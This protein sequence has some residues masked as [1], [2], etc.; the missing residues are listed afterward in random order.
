MYK[1]TLTD[2][3]IR[4][5]DGSIIP[6][7]ALN[8]DYKT[9]LIWAAQGNTAAAADVS[10]SVATVSALQGMLAIGQNPALAAAY[11]SWANDPGRTFAQRAFID[12]AQTWRRDDL[13]LAAAATAFG[14]SGEQV[15]GL[16][17]LA[18]TL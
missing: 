18:A 6:A 13:T 11:E 1:L 3:V 10:P 2:S 16:F 17:E 9:Y 4:V 14:L 5:A 12:K 15:D 7:D 8:A